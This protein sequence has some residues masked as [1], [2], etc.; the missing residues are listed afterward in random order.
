MKSGE[1]Y[2][3]KPTLYP[4]GGDLKTNPTQKAQETHRLVSHP[5]L[6]TGGGLLQTKVIRYLQF[7]EKKKF[8]CIT[9]FTPSM[10]NDCSTTDLGE[11]FSLLRCRPEALPP[12]LT[13]E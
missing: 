7:N 8:N 1:K 13:A 2:F 5:S 11:E 6:W 9:S 4:G 10:F 12:T 3:S